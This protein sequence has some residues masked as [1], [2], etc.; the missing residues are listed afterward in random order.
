MLSTYVNN[1]E[2]TVT[3][4]NLGGTKHFEKEQA[5]PVSKC[6]MTLI[7]LATGLNK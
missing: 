5:K 4:Q 3:K 1:L 6:K 2:E 7:N